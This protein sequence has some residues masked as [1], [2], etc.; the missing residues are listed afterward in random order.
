MQP[1]YKSMKKG[2]TLI[3]LLVVISIIAL[4]SSVALASLNSARAKAADAAIKSNLN[5]VR[6]QSNIYF[7]ANGTYLGFFDDSN[8]LQKRA[9]AAAKA[10]VGGAGYEGGPGDDWW[11]VIVPLKTGGGM[12]WCV[13]GR[14][15]SQSISVEEIFLT[16][17]S[18]ADF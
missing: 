6:T 11:F 13:D 17:T 1:N 15:A 14:G 18:C 4:L 8:S 12:W 16:E 3:E 2:F 10:I 7:D 9:I 5:T